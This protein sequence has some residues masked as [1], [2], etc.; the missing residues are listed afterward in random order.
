MVDEA[1][2]S[3]L[4]LDLTQRTLNT[5]GNVRI[6]ISLRGE[7]PRQ[8]APLAMTLTVS[9]LATSGV[10]ELFRTAGLQEP[11]SVEIMHRYGGSPLM[12]SM[13]ARELLD[14]RSTVEDLLSPDGMELSS[15]LARRVGRLSPDARRILEA[16]SSQPALE[17]PVASSE[18]RD[19]AVESRALEELAAAGLVNY[20]AKSHAPPEI[21][22]EAVRSW[23]LKNLSKPR[24]Q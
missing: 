22:H 16:L 17:K 8:L 23:V 9:D 12:L 11:A 21:V 3:T 4:A 14:G 15:F 18:V 6:L 13:L 19:S 7:V 2:D 24:A 20:G 5:N 1:R 10:E